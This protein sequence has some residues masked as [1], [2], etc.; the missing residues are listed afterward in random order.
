M[1]YLLRDLLGLVQLAADERDDLDAVDVLRCAS[2][3]LMPK[4]PARRAR[5]RY[6]LRHCSF[7]RIRWPTRRVRRRHVVEAMQTFGVTPAHRQ[8]AARDQPHHQL[9]AFASRPRARSRCAASSR[10]PP[11]RRSDGRGSVVPFRVD[12][13]RARA[14]QLVAHAAGAPDLHVQVFV[15]GLDGLADAPCPRL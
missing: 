11:G 13:A 10:A 2:R 7:S 14:L 5:L 6:V 12:Q 8:R 3:C 9:D 1:P 15:E 4:A